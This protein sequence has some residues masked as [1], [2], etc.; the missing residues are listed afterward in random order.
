M[1]QQERAS[2]THFLKTWPE[3]FQDVADGKKIFEYR[4]N[5][6][7]FQVGDTLILKEWQPLDA[8]Y[9]T[10]RVE[11]RVVQYILYGG[12]FGLPDDFCIM[13]FTPPEL[14]LIGDDEIIGDFCKTCDYVLEGCKEHNQASTC[15]S[16]REALRQKKA[17]AQA[18][19]DHNK[20]EIKGA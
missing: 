9:F 6:R 1:T 10:G 16:Y 2:K 12:K 19:L 11:K 7:D 17:T 8:G 3:V 4:K 14:T 15:F 13:Q 18:Q 5:D 20:R